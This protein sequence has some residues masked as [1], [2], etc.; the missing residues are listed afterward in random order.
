MVLNRP[1]PIPTFGFVWFCVAFTALARNRVSAREKRVAAER[2][3][4]A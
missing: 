4:L 3:T 2:K 1:S